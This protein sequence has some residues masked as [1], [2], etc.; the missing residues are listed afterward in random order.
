MR[1]EA[2]LNPRAALTDDELGDEGRGNRRRGAGRDTGTS[3]RAN[4]VH[5]KQPGQTNL[6]QPLRP[7]AKTADGPRT[8]GRKR[9]AGAQAEEELQR[10]ETSKRHHQAP[11]ENENPDPTHQSNSAQGL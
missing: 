7:P 1:K 11:P 3:H 5:K 8:N 2:K 10:P 9:N 4:P 6:H